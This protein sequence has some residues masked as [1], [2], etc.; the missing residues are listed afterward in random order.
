MVLQAALPTE[1]MPFPKFLKT[2]DFAAKR[3]KKHKGKA[4]ASF[5][6]LARLFAAKFESGASGLLQS[7]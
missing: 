6:S 2:N 5:A 7:A 3:H 4:L 1:E